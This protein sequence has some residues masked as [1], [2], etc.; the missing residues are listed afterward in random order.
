MMPEDNQPRTAILILDRDDEDREQIISALERLGFAAVNA[1]SGGEA[2]KRARQQ[3]TPLVIVDTAT[4]NLDIPTFLKELY[5]VDRHIGVVCLSDEVGGGGSQQQS[6]SQVRHYLKRPFR[7]A[8]LLGAI[9][10]VAGTPL[11]RSA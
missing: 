11:R 5:Q 8:H 2:L 3:P 4:P 1:G 9:L 10:E 6:V 7:R